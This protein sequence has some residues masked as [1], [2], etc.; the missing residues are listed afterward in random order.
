MSKNY[1]HLSLI[2]RYQIEVLLQTGCKQKEIAAQLQVHP[3]TISREIKRNVGSRGLHANTY[4][5]FNAHR[6]AELRHHEKPKHRVFLEAQKLQVL[7]LLKD[8]KWSPEIISHTLR[9]QGQVMVSAER[10][11]QWIWSCKR[12][13]R[14]QDVMFKDAYKYLRHGRR[15]RK[16]GNRK[17]NR[18]IIHGRVS[19]EQRPSIVNKRKRVGD[20]EVDLMLGKNH[21]GVVL[22]MTDRATL[23]TQLDKLPTKDSVQIAKAII[24][25]LS[26][27]DYKVHTLT[28]DND[29]SFR[30]HQIVA[31]QLQLKTYF[32]RPYTSQ[33]KGTVENRIGVL[34]RFLPK[35]TDLSLINHQ[36]IKKI[37]ALLN[38]RPVRKF[39]YQ[40]PNQVLQQKI[41]LAT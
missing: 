1:T 28:F 27:L 26:L 19:I 20:I 9:Q 13:N 12:T 11:Y 5:G 6:R 21:Q 40:T 2:Q 10:I 8:P 37:Q 41:A 14:E 32:T 23:H 36:R 15:R 16:R 18:G 7:Q 3:S 31:N 29:Q 34:R 30:H 39:N 24:K 38:E 25:R 35:K 33:D 22:V 17:D 4:Y